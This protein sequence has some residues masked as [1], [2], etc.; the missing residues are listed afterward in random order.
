MIQSIEKQTGNKS[1]MAA[2][3]LMLLLINTANTFA[4]S[5]VNYATDGS[6]NGN[7]GSLHNF[8]LNGSTSNWVAGTVTG[9][10]TQFALPAITGTATV[11]AGAAT[12][13]S[14]TLGGGTWSSSN[15][16]V[17]TVNASGLLT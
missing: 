12:Q 2:I 14:N 16:L 8:T 7:T 13:L 10:C 3:T 6:G 15:N 1:V 17:A 9:T 11:C 5:A 4:Q